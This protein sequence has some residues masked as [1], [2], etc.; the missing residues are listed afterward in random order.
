MGEDIA[1]PDLDRRRRA[2]DHPGFD[3]LASTQGIDS[4]RALRFSAFLAE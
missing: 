2:L 1:F 4:V 3:D